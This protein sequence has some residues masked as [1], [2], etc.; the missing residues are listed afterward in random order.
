MTGIGIGIGTGTGIGIG[1]DGRQEG[2]IW[3][4]WI[5]WL[6]LYYLIIKI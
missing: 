3:V 4:I 5:T 2:S 6:N 1:T